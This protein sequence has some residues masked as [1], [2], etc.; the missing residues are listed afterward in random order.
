MT[1][2]LVVDAIVS[3]TK[4]GVATMTG[5]A[6]CSQP[7][8]SGFLEGTLSQRQGQRI[9]TSEIFFFGIDCGPAGRA[10]AF[11]VEGFNGTF[12]PRKGSVSVFAEVCGAL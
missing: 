10:F 8:E 2:D 3:V 5:T 11:E 1:I 4:A 7:A 9:I 12:A 6:T